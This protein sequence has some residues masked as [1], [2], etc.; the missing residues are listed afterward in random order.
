VS[1]PIVTYD[2]EADAAYIYFSTG[3]V[4]ESE[5]VSRGVVFDYDRDGCIIG[6]EV[7]GA[8][9]KLPAAL[10][11]QSLPPNRPERRR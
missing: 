3:P 8:N 1:G 9:K 2:P 4:Q 11:A 5:E 6:M 10:L 7:L